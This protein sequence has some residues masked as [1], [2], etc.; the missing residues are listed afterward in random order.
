LNTVGGPR[1]VLIVGSGGREH[2]LAWKLRQSP[3]VGQIFVAPG[4]G[5]TA[6]IAANIDLGERDIDGIRHFVA[7]HH[8]EL[9]VVGPELP[10]SLGLS[11]QLASLGGCAVFGPSQAAARLE[12]SKVFAKD[13]M[14]RHGLP[15]AAYRTVAD[16][17]EGQ[18]AV[19]ELGL[20]VAVK[21][22]GLA[23]GK[24]VTVCHTTA[25]A[26]NAL[27]E[28]F[29]QNHFGAAGCRA[30]VEQGLIGEEVSVL[31]FCDGQH[32][33]P[34]VPAQD[35]KAV[36]DGDRGPNTGGMGSYAPAAVLGAAALQEA[37]R[38]VLEPAVAGMRAEG[39]PYRGV[40]YA[41]LMLTTDGPQVLEFNARLGDP[42]TQSI[43]PLLDADLFDIL[44]ACAVDELAA[45][46]GRWLPETAV[47][48]V[49]ASRGYPGSYPKGLPIHGLAE[50]E[51]QP[52]VTVFHASTTRR[53]EGDFFTAGGRVLGVTC[54]AADLRAAVDGAYA[55]V[56]RIHFDGM[57]YRTDIAAKGLNRR[58]R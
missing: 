26:T 48:I 8:I 14:A 6:G 47:C 34:M 37:V 52:G 57:H 30:I 51:G 38:T 15:T 19:C 41:G 33:I 24:G 20:P 32:A 53:H 29:V 50:A 25:E 45:V 22:D 9:T 42:E 43:V 16:F 44:H 40:L 2:A 5:G 36:F 7:E 23:A 3:Q 13:F 4:N 31:A 56:S 27:R 35:H 18:R 54:R 1:D 28:I 17:D 11:D 10:L 46:P 49:C 12:T 58:E 55:A 39:T 21:V